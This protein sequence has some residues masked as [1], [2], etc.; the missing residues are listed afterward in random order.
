[1]VS[2]RSNK[3]QQVTVEATLHDN[4]HDNGVLIARA[5]IPAGAT[6]FLGAKAPAGKYIRKL[7]IRSSSPAPLDIDKMGL[8]MVKRNAL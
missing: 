3:A 1:M 7:D 6:V 8:V 4:Y 2:N 5:S